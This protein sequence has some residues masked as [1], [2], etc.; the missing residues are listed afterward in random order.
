MVGIDAGDG[1]VSVLGVLG[2]L[3][4]CV[5]IVA[6]GVT[7]SRWRAGAADVGGGLGARRLDR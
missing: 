2:L 5:S 1:L 3:V 4:A 7:I 6:A